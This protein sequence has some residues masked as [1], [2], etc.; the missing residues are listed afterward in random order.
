MLTA[1]ASPTDPLTLEA[2]EGNMRSEDVSNYVVFLLRMATSAEVKRRAEFFAPFVLGL[3]DKDVDAFCRGCIDPMGEE[4]DHVHL[5]ALTDAL[6]VPLRVV[7]L[8]R[9]NAP[10]GGGGG[11]SGGTAEVSAMPGDSTGGGTAL[12]AAAVKVD[13]HNF[14]PDQFAGSPEPR[15]HL[16]YRP[17]HYDVLY[18]KDVA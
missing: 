14:V 15:V 13:I 5:V 9:S 7:Y 6:Q 17:G 2:L 18:V 8:D 4:S 12:S 1:I 16:L 11:S 3:T 10:A